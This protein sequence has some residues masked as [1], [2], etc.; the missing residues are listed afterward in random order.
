M[1]EGMLSTAIKENICQD[2]KAWSKASHN[3]K[4]RLHIYVGY[5]KRKTNQY[6][7]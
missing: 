3:K 2:Q 7:K 6:L 5:Y 4:K 1:Y